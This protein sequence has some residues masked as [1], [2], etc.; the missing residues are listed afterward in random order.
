MGVTRSSCYGRFV[1]PYWSDFYTAHITLVNTATF[2]NSTLCAAVSIYIHM[3]SFAWLQ[4]T[5]SISVSSNCHK[6][7]TVTNFRAVPMRPLV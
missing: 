1:S 4:V 6:S 2:V 7:G 3:L 5:P